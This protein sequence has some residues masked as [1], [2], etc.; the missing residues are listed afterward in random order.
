MFLKF[1]ILTAISATLIIYFQKPLFIEINKYISIESFQT[2]VDNVRSTFIWIGT[3]GGHLGHTI[4]FRKPSKLKHSRLFSVNDLSKYNGIEGSKGLY[5]SILGKVYDV[6]KGK[7][8]Y[9]PGGS[10]HSFAGKDASRAFIT[11]DFNETGLSDDVLD[12]TPQELKSIIHWTEFYARDYKYRGKLIGRYYDAYGNPT[13]YHNQVMNKIKTARNKMVDE[14][15]EKLSYPPC[16][17]EWSQ[18]SGT[19]VWCSSLR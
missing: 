3:L 16:N 5:L 7:Q 11:G 6:K 10:Y 12:L 13:S 19:R 14:E 8:H 9:G 4:T 1:L 2:V 17:S 15:S 18:D